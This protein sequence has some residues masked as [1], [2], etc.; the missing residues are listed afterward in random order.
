MAVGLL[1]GCSTS[2]ATGDSNGT[3]SDNTPSASA[4]STPSQAAA[5]N[6]KFGQAFTFKSGLKVT[7][8]APEAYTPSTYASG[9]AAN[10]IKFNV[11]I[12]NGSD[13]A[14]T[15]VIFQYTA[16]AGGQ[17]GN[18]IFDTEQK[19]G[20]YDGPNSVAPGASASYV[21]GYGFAGSADGVTVT[22]DPSDFVSKPATF[23]A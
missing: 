21:I 19:V 4:T 15:P 18:E 8:S 14:V 12:E 2:P 11:T 6:P 1:A 20:A 7:I 5:E 22:F 3:I 16:T 17:A 23:T 10:N 9:A 13:E